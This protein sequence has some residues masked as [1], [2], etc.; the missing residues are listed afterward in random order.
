MSLAKNAPPEDAAETE[1][2]RGGFSVNGSKVEGR[3]APGFERVRDSFARTFADGAE[4]GASLAVVRDGELVVDLWGG[5][6]DAGKTQAWKRDTVANVWSTTKGIVALCFAMLVDRGKLSYKDEVSKY[7]PEFAA[8]GK[9]DVTIEMMLSH[10]AGLCGL[11]T[12]AK[13]ADFYDHASTA[14]RLAAQA[15]IWEPGS[16]SGYHAI[17]VGFLANEVFRRVDGRTLRAFIAEEIAGPFNIDVAIG[18]APSEEGRMAP[19]IPA[20]S[21]GMPPADTLNAS[22]KLALGNPPLEATAPN[23]RAWRAAEIPAANGFATAEAL[24]R[25]YGALAS[26]GRIGGRKLIGK[27]AIAQATAPRIANVDE[28]LGMDVRWAAGFLL[29]GMGVY[30]PNAEA[31]GHSGWGGSFGSADPK[32]GIAIGYVM[33]QMGSQLAGDPRSVAYIDAIYASLS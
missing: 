9:G 3:C 31:F 28:V 1:E 20:T 21:S 16:R 23:E 10:Q 12:P 15:P 13:I 26:D 30:G 14:A 7:W 5:W 17:T 8:N 32:A 25:L 33:N 2:F 6:R 24:A 27:E 18:L 29:N 22:Q 11:S 19:I 4:V